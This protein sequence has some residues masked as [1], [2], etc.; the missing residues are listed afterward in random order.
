MQKQCNV[1][2]TQMKSSTYAIML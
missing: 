1:N 2:N